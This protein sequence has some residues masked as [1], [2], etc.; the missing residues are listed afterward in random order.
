MIENRMIKTINKIKSILC[1]RICTI[2]NKSINHLARSFIVH[3]G[4]EIKPEIEKALEYPTTFLVFQ[5]LITK[6]AGDRFSLE[7]HQAI[8]NNKPFLTKILGGVYSNPYRIKILIGKSFLDPWISVIIL[9]DS[10]DNTIKRKDYRVVEII[11]F[12]IRSLI[13]DDPSKK[14]AYQEETTGFCRP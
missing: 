5:K 7:T 11:V 4:F 10:L 6:D 13:V 8:F 14:K 1:D 9:A 12:H 3:P 2:L